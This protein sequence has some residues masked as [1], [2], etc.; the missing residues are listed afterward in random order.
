M[1]AAIRAPK[2]KQE[3]IGTN[4]NQYRVVAVVVVVVVAVVVVKPYAKF[5]GGK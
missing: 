2:A 1:I 5:P 4:V 3:H